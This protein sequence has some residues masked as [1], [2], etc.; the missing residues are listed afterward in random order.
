MKKMLILTLCLV[1]AV[2]VWGQGLE[3]F[4]N[5]DYAETAYVDGSFVGEGGITWNYFHVTGAVSGANDNSIEGNGMILRRSAVPSRIISDPIPNGIGNFS[6]QMRKAYTSGGDRQVALFINDTWVAD[7]QIF[8]GAQGGDPTIHEFIVNGVNIPGNI[9]MEIRHLQGG[10]VNRQ[11]TIDNI[12]WTAYGS[13]QQYVVNPTFNPPGGHYGSAL[14]V[15]ISTTTDNASIYYTIDGSEPS[16]TSTLYTAPVNISTPTT[17][18]ARAY[19]AGY[20]PSAIVSANYGFFVNVASL[21]E[22]WQ[23]PA[24]NNTVYHIPGN[25]I[26]T[27][28]QSNRHQKFVQDAGAAILIDDLPGVITSNY[29][30]GDAIAGL[31]GKLNLYFET[32]QFL[33]TADPGPA[34]SS[35]NDITV[36]IVT[37]AQLNSDIG[38]NQYQ[39]RLVQINEVSFDSPSGNY[40][41]NPAVTYP[42]SDV[43]GAMTFRT[44][45]YDVDYI[46]TPM[47]TG[48]FSVMGI[49][50]HFQNAAQITP[51][52]LA[53]FNP[54]PDGVG[55]L[56][57]VVTSAGAPLAGAQIV[58]PGTEFSVGSAADG[59]YILHLIPVGTHSVTASKTGYTSVTHTVTIV[60]GETATQNFALEIVP[61]QVSVSGRIV[62]SGA[63]DVGLAGATISLSGFA[64]YTA[65]TNASGQFTISD[66]SANHTYAYSVSAPG[67]ATATGDLVVGGNDVNMGDIILTENINPP[68]NVIADLMD[69]G[70]EA[71]IS[72]QSPDLSKGRALLGYYV[73]RFLTADQ[74]NE[75][76][77]MSYTT[78]PISSTIVIDPT[79]AILP[80][81]SYKWAVK[82]VYTGD[83]ASAAAF[84]NA[85][86]KEELNGSIAGFVKD[87][88]DHAIAG[89]TMTIAGG[90]STTT[91]NSGAYSFSLPPGHYVLTATA[92]G[93][94]T[95]TK[96]NIL[97]YENQET[98]VNCIMTPV[99]NEDELAPVAVT[100]LGGNYPNPFNPETTISYELKDAGN[101]HLDVYNARGQ[102]VR[103]LVNANQAAGRYRVVFN[104]SDD[105]G[106]PLA[107]GLYLYRLS[108]GAYHSTRKMMLME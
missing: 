20:E 95:I 40:T 41:T 72:W 102:L 24:D 17:L 89:A 35:G 23:Q 54:V 77:W 26:L 61:V 63:P 107:S 55:S 74:G 104:G 9:T 28:K 92:E 66:V 42:I 52:R 94:T 45:F 37:V 47:H 46:D 73:Y 105:M 39:S 38:V 29:Q 57:G 96:A 44:S 13:G 101:V 21:S 58:V 18:K 50:A 86:V 62:G 43:S 87:Q 31:T 33:P 30:I 79:W 5:F 22:L 53:D 108:S 34:T 70:Q 59:S 15:T 36:P 49:I 16:Q 32:L 83:V 78:Y 100:A 6:V 85:L 71:R 103:S 65:T 27:F 88:E 56:S 64:P 8:G 93:F 48:E 68:Q 99:A 3:T 19:A 12:S 98:T 11:L 84:S 51:R 69:D 91:D 106:N 80:S 67:Y 7:S 2:A 76:N 1:A 60:E 81:G 25:V 97:V 14:D 82:A 75:A 4:A 90:S 10:T